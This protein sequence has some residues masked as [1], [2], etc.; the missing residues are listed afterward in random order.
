MLQ[1]RLKH[2]VR[3]HIFAVPKP[4]FYQGSRRFI[5]DTY[6]KMAMEDFDGLLDFDRE[7]FP[8]KDIP[9]HER[10]VGQKEGL[11]LALTMFIG[12]LVEG[13]GRVR[14]PGLTRSYIFNPID[15]SLDPGFCLPDLEVV[16]LMTYNMRK[17]QKAAM[18]EIAR[19]YEQ[20][21]WKTYIHW[22]LIPEESRE[23]IRPESGRFR[24]TLTMVQPAELQRIAQ[25]HLDYDPE[26]LCF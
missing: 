13:V 6:T 19:F 5:A 11:D 10:R 7:Y 16:S 26:K 3:S 21:G 22:R 9:D 17:K 24:S 1:K 14:L 25:E 2:N 12:Q 20:Q 23:S 18:E 8:H 15:P 4:G